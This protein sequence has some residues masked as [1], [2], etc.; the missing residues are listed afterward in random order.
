MNNLIKKSIVFIL[1]VIVLLAGINIFMGVKTTHNKEYESDIISEHNAKVLEIDN[2]RIENLSDDDDKMATVKIKNISKLNISQIALY[3]DEAD[4][5]DSVISDSKLDID[6]TLS[7]DEVVRME[8]IPKDYT[9][10]I[11]ITGYT[12]LVEDSKVYVNLKNDEVNILEN[13]EYLDNSKNYEV[14][15]INKI[16]DDKNNTTDSALN[17][18]IKNISEK[19]LGNI[20]L[21]IAE[22]NEDQEIV[23]ID[24][25]IYNSILKPDEEAQISATLYNP[26]YSIK[27]LGYTY[28]DMENKSNIDIDLITHKVNI[29]ESKQ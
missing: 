21:R 23:K 27:I 7:S 16:D 1:I 3:Y 24:H 5:S 14:M 29:V 26:N 28:D 22:I 10:S 9:E 25:I 17:I 2:E 13:K 18:E 20:V 6:I 19:N 4:K 15:S 11:E 12:Y 8:F